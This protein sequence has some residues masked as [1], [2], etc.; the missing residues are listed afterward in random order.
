ML[1]PKEAMTEFISEVLPEIQVAA[2]C[3]S[4]ETK[5]N[6]ANAAAWSLHN[7]VGT[8]IESC[9]LPCSHSIISGGSRAASSLMQH[10]GVLPFAVVTAPH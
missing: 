2:L 7:S 1:L 4:A 9:T 5:S 10:F 6:L 8:N 3:S